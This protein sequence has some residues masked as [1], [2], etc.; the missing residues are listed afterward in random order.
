M[1][2]VV[3][4]GVIGVGGTLLGVSVQELLTR[5]RERGKRRRL[6][7]RA[8]AAITGELIATVSILDKALER[9]AWWAE[10]DEPRRDDWSRY[11][12]ALAEEVDVETVMRIGIAYDTVRSLAASRSS[13]LTPASTGRLR[14]MLR[15]DPQGRSFF[16]LIWTNDRWPWA[17]VETEQ[18]R[19][20]IWEVLTEH[21]WP[22][23]KRYS[24]GLK[25][26]HGSYLKAN[27]R[28][29]GQASCSPRMVPSG[30]KDKRSMKRSLRRSQKRAWT[31]LFKSRERDGTRRE[32]SSPIHS[33]TFRYSYGSTF[34][35]N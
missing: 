17:A 5:M 15:D 31:R 12:D 28:A 11:R 24:N 8:V 1:D 27:R 29:F 7:R 10:G 9:Q 23:Q 21:L 30:L 22:L 34:L 6:A 18:T 26:S 4:G 25:M 13:P 20:A 14:K 35:R 32:G 16:S 33:S 19:A 3:T 2:P